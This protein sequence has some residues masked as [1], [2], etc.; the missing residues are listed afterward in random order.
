MKPVAEMLMACAVTVI[1]FPILLII[2]AGTAWLLEKI[3]IRT[4]K[5]TAKPN[6]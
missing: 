3:F 4:P 2:G 6:P 5:R 1:A